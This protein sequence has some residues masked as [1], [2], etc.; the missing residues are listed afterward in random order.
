MKDKAVM[1]EVDLTN[2]LNLLQNAMIIYSQRES[3]DDNALNDGF[4]YIEFANNK[5]SELF[6]I[7]LETLS[8]RVCL[9]RQ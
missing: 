1:K 9:N 6:K 8:A 7:K 2:V 3:D 5:S 4:P